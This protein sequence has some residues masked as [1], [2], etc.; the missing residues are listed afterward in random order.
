LQVRKG[1]SC[2]LYITT[3]IQQTIPPSS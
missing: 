3:Y 1:Q 2:V